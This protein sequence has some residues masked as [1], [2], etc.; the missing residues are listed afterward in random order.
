MQLQGSV[1]HIAL[2]QARDLVGRLEAQLA[3]KQERAETLASHLLAAREEVG[4]LKRDLDAER[5][6]RVRAETSVQNQSNS[7]AKWNQACVEQTHEISRLQAQLRAAQERPIPPPTESRPPPAHDFRGL[8]VVE[9][10]LDAGGTFAEWSAILA[11]EDRE[12]CIAAYTFDLAS[13]VIA[14]ASVRRR[15]PREPG[16][17]RILADEGHTES[18]KGAGQEFTRAVREGIQVRV[19]H[20]HL[21]QLAYPIADSR[22][23]RMQEYGG[24]HAKVLIAVGQKTAVIGSTNFS[25]SSQCNIELG[26]KVKLTD[27]GLRDLMRWFDECWGNSVTH[28]I[29]GGASGSRSHPSRRPQR[30]RSRGAS[31]S[32]PNRQ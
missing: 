27:P 15:N 8:G 11:V 20:G 28:V 14:A 26:V 4:H 19:G 31:R 10:F 12:V 5:D 24:H 9:W 25:Q 2:R 3:V 21:I 30:P 32:W 16:V 17:V 23:P 29:S 13:I 6:R 7:I 22:A 18:L 1:T